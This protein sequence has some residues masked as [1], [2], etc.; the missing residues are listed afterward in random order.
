MVASLGV[1]VRFPIRHNASN[2]DAEEKR[3]EDGM[4]SAPVVLDVPGYFEPTHKF[5]NSAAMVLHMA[6]PDITTGEVEFGCHL[7]VFYK[8]DLAEAFRIVSNYIADEQVSGR[9][10][11]PTWDQAKTMIEILAEGEN[12]CLTESNHG[13]VNAQC[14]IEK[15]SAVDYFNSVDASYG[16]WQGGYGQ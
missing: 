3:K 4:T 6:D 10:E 5:Y 2:Q 1:W 13:F 16:Y 11:V 14:Y 15:S 7:S 8:V 12:W 9:A